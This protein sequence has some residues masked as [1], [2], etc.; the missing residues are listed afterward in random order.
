M[1]TNFNP[2][3]YNP[4]DQRIQRNVELMYNGGYKN[5]YDKNKKSTYR[6][7]RIE[8]LNKKALSMKNNVD[9]LMNEVK[10]WSSTF[11]DD[12]DDKNIER[13]LKKY[14]TLTD[15]VNE[16]ANKALDNG[17]P[18][19]ISKIHPEISFKYNSYNIY[20][21]K[22]G[23]SK[24]TFVMKQF[25]KLSLIEHDYHLIIYVAGTDSDDTINSLSNF[26]NIPIMKTNYD[27]IEEQFNELIELK[28]KYNSMV[29]GKMKK[30]KSILKP[31]RIKDFSKKRLH[32]IVFF[33]D[34]TSLLK[35]KKKKDLM[36][37]FTKCRHFNLTVIICI[38]SWVGIGKMDRDYITSV[39]LYK[40]FSKD[41]MKLIHDQLA[42]DMDFDCFY[43]KYLELKK[44]QKLVIDSDDSSVSIE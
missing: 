32:T 38:H 9:D 17:M 21:G 29:D 44:Y 7:R 2:F 25:M 42:I 4:Y 24:T 36:Q 37:K 6:G 12:D 39:A 14:H 35:D 8:R 43:S 18:K 1:N 16:I 11:D 31:L 10:Y 19:F 27:D 20:C 3:L 5:I 26:I 22:P 15:Y 41:R 40:G 23:S 28:E 34:A 33:D 13:D 30:D